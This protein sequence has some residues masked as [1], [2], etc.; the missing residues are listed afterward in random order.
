MHR[1][2][3]KPNVG[4]VPPTIAA[5]SPSDP[6]ATSTSMYSNPPARPA[7][8]PHCTVRMKR[9]PGPSGSR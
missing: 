5:I 6:V 3:T 4:D 9:T 2:T 8:P 1:C 7:N